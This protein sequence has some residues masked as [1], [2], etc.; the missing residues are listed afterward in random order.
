MQSQPKRTD[1]FICVVTSDRTE[2][3]IIVRFIHIAILHERRRKVSSELLAA[4]KTEHRSN[5]KHIDAD[6]RPV[7]VDVFY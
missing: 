2:R 4:A 5:V 3:L 6:R 7:T 1:L